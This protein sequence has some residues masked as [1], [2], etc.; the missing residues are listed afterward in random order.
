MVDF[1]NIKAKALAVLGRQPQK[2]QE[3]LVD[4]HDILAPRSYYDEDLLERPRALYTID[5][6]RS[7]RQLS[8]SSQNS[9]LAAALS[10]IDTHRIDNQRVAFLPDD[11][12]HAHL[13]HTRTM[14]SASSGSLG[15]GLYTKSSN[16]SDSAASKS[17][18]PTS[19][20]SFTPWLKRQGHRL[21]DHYRRNS[22]ESPM[23]FRAM[24]CF[25]PL[26][27]FA[28]LILVL[29]LTQ[30]GMALL[31]GVSSYIK[32]QGFPAPVR[33]ML[34]ALQIA[35]GVFYAVVCIFGMMVMWGNLRR[36]PTAAFCFIVINGLVCV[37]LIATCVIW[38][39]FSQAGRNDRITRCRE[40]TVLAGPQPTS[41]LRPAPAWAIEECIREARYMG[42]WMIVWGVI[43]A[44]M[45]YFSIILCFWGY[46]YWQMVKQFAAA[47]AKKE[48][49]AEE[50]KRAAP[51]TPLG[52]E[53]NTS[54]PIIQTPPPI[55]TALPIT[56]ESLMANN[57]RNSP[58]HSTVQRISDTPTDGFLSPTSTGS[59]ASPTASRASQY[60]PV[61]S[62]SLRDS[63]SSV[64]NDKRTST[65][66]IGNTI[67][68]LN[69][70]PG[71]SARPS[72]GNLTI[73][74]ATPTTPAGVSFMSSRGSTGSSPSSPP[75]N[76]PLPQLPKFPF[77]LATTVRTI[78]MS[79]AGM[80][81]PTPPP[82]MTPSTPMSSRPKSPTSG[83]LSVGGFEFPIAPTTAAT[84]TR[85]RRSMS[86]GA[87]S[88]VMI[89]LGQARSTPPPPV[90]A[91]APSKAVVASST[92]GSSSNVG[93]V[94]VSSGRGRVNG[95]PRAP[96]RRGTI[97]AGDEGLSR[98]GSTSSTTSS[99]SSGSSKEDSVTASS[100]VL[101][102]E[103]V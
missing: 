76:T 23:W 60:R 94:V 90:P 31:W 98:S 47:D 80:V 41:P 67:F 68:R 46:R 40:M 7:L 78:D 1:G 18:S 79:L 48:A 54:S 82:P 43:H 70:S 50:K 28:K 21:S 83:I 19:S 63:L 88:E 38:F 93:M 62:T 39:F 64:E 12:H 75:P 92:G 86:E 13:T 69:P 37:T 25:V 87:S 100:T 32:Q 17:A 33:I 99:S 24:T 74:S 89:A 52:A 84:T 103:V 102:R 101:P 95:F 45:F 20:G 57:K 61:I 15:K 96:V 27:H 36:S 16:L 10:S 77:Q 26:D 34:P 85:K 53:S 22:P 59:M 11:P 29:G 97:H 91:P 6:E 73:P 3:D 81:L 4:D 8:I 65:V 49:D 58:N 56:R 30:A 66:I 42:M 71:K 9:Q 55:G 14:S 72:P 2:K 44:V 35:W 51:W 5:E